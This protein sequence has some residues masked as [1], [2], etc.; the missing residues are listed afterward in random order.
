MGR[1]AIVVAVASVIAASAPRAHACSKR[2]QT[3]FEL[4]DL[5]ETVAVAKVRR[6]PPA[7]HGLGPAGDVDLAVRQ[8][9]K[10]KAGKLVAKETNTSC[11]AGFAVGRTALVF[12]GADGWPVGHYEGYVRDYAKLLP[13][14]ERYAAATTEADRGQVVIDALGDPA[15][16]EEAGWWIV[17]HPELLAR[18]DAVAIERVRVAADTSR[19][20]SSQLT[21]ILVRLHRPVADAALAQRGRFVDQRLR[22]LSAITTFEAVTDPAVLADAIASNTNVELDR[23]AALDRCERVRGTRLYW[24]TRYYGGV[25]PQFW[26]ALATACRT[27]TAIADR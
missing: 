26:A 12:V 6:M 13:T 2:H 5:A 23:I 18:L 17:D 15:M 11:A 27:G 21:A 25:A 3:V 16:A 9:L 19:W 22:D 8:L 14:L 4:F 7:A 24:F 1:V 20:A 10:G